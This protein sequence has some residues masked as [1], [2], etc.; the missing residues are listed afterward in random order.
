METGKKDKYSL[1]ID[2]YKFSVFLEFLYRKN[3]SPLKEVHLQPLDRCNPGTKAFIHL[4]L[5]DASSQHKGV[6]PL[7]SAFCKPNCIQCCIHA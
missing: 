7:S 2:F 4:D 3:S 5:L 6:L 1:Y